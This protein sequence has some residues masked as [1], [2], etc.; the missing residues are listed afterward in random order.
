MEKITVV[1]AHPIERICRITSDWLVSD[2]SDAST[3]MHKIAAVLI[4]S[5]PLVAHAIKAGGVTLALSRANRIYVAGPMTGYPDLNFPA[6]NAAAEAL[7]ADGWDAVNP[8]DHGIVDGAEWG[9][10]L[11]ADI[12]QLAQCEAIYLLPGWPQ[13]KGAQLEITIAKAL[14]M[15]VLYA[16]GAEST[17]HPDDPTM[18]CSGLGTIRMG[19]AF[20]EARIDV[21]GQNGPTGEHYQPAP[22]LGEVLTA[23]APAEISDALAGGDLPDG[24]TWEQA[25]EWANVL[26]SST[27]GDYFW[28]EAFKHGV[29]YEWVTLALSKTLQPK[30]PSGWKLIATRPAL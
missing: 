10:Y 13:S 16:P 25:P 24:L 21:I 9:D 22:T 14:G 11:R 12:A 7:Q 27:G 8:A 19:G 15:N 30:R 5:G 23:V 18:R 17:T 28:A 2:D 1:P 3:A 6:F 26:M 29:R 20:D 4:E